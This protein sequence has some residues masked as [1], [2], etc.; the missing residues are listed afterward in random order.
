MPLARFIM[1]RAFLD[2]KKAGREK[3]VPQIVVSCIGGL[4]VPTQRGN[5]KNCNRFAESQNS[6]VDRSKA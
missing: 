6:L 4:D 2:L 5:Q 1:K 3:R